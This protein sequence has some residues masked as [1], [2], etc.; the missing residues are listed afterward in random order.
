MNNNINSEN[1]TNT[2]PNNNS[3]VVD[4]DS[5]NN[6]GSGNNNISSQDNNTNITTD[7][8]TSA[9]TKLDLDSIDNSKARISEA[10]D[11]Y[12][13]EKE[14]PHKNYYDELEVTREDMFS[15]GLTISDRALNSEIL[16]DED[17]EII[18][19]IWNKTYE[20]YEALTDIAA[21]ME[22]LYNTDKTRSSKDPIIAKEVLKTDDA[23]CK[24]LMNTVSITDRVVRSNDP[25]LDPDYENSMR[26][27]ELLASEWSEKS[28][29][30][31]KHLNYDIEQEEKIIQDLKEE[32]EIQ[33]I[34]EEEQDSK[35]RKL[36]ENS[37]IEENE[38][39][40]KQKTDIEKNQ[41]SSIIDDYADPS[42]EP[43]DWTGGDD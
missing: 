13:Q 38:D 28:R 21:Q 27:L 31:M 7:N 34:K 8:T 17:K 15:A 3:A 16:N 37:D 19:G 25:E 1:P 33:S 6:N 9:V 30:H 20:D 14:N 36:E 23:F 10:L 35:K 2:N 26:R 4:S 42:I 12:H 5:N 32:Q 29:E 18:D 24:E 11:K 43:G 41:A 22:G 40:K 39:N